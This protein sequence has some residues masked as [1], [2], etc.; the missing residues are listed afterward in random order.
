MIWWWFTIFVGEKGEYFVGPE[1]SCWQRNIFQEIFKNVTNRLR[2]IKDGQ[3]I[4]LFFL[5]AEPL[6]QLHFLSLWDIKKI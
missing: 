3:T 5:S 6:F 1:I 2:R 4:F